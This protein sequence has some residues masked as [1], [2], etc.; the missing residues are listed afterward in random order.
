MCGFVV[1]TFIYDTACSVVHFQ[2]TYAHAVLLMFY[3]YSQYW[4]CSEVCIESIL[5]FYQ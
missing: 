1:Y 5:D 3:V 2:C 4:H